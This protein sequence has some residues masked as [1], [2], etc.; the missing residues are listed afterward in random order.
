MSQTRKVSNLVIHACPAQVKT[1]VESV[2]PGVNIRWSRQD[3]I[4]DSNKAEIELKLSHLEAE[5][6]IVSLNKLVGLYVDLIMPNRLFMLVPGLGVYS[7]ETNQAGEIVIS[8]S[9]I[10]HAIE[11]S[12]G[13]YKELTRLMRLALGQ[14]WDDLLEPFRA[15]RFGAEIV[16]LN[17][18]G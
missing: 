2:L 9:R 16:L 4:P 8:E 7:A 5:E 1:E 6:L 13:N 18:A 15:R 10:T 14:S 17:R 12:N 11:S 3:L